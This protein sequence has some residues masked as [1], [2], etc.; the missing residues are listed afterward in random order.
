MKKFLVIGNPIDHSLSPKLHNYWFKKYGL[1]EYQYDKKEIT[2]KDLESTV[3][4][5]RKNF[6]TGINVTVPFKKSIIRFCDTLDGAADDIQSVNTISKKDGKIIG[7]NTDSYGFKDC[8]DPF[9]LKKGDHF[10]GE[11]YEKS[12]FVLG[13]GGVTASI[14]DALWGFRPKK[15]FL[16]NRTK[17]KALELKKKFSKKFDDIEVLDW[18]K[19]PKNKSSIVINTT[20]LGLKEEDKINIDFSD[21]ESKK[22]NQILFIDLIYSRKTNFL[23]DAQKRGNLTA[24]GK[25]MFLGQAK[26][27]FNIWTNILPKIDEGVMR[28]LKND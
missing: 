2:E 10:I 27:S 3:N 19:K 9:F 16:S 7:W 13:A 4:N 22:N 25:I 6:I 15:I 12:V 26:Y 28:L 23:E 11:M 24:D 5:V 8:L 18:G 1:T 20:S 14:L 21:Y 17:S